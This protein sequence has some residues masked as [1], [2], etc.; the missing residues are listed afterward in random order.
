[1]AFQEVESVTTDT[2]VTP[3]YVSL[4]QTCNRTTFSMPIRWRSFTLV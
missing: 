2:H 3:G 4:K 1:M